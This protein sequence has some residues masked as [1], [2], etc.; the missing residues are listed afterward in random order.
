MHFANLIFCLFWLI[1]GLSKGR[2]GNHDRLR[3]LYQPVGTHRKEKYSQLFSYIQ[4][5]NN[6]AISCNEV[7]K[8]EYLPR[9]K[10]INYFYDNVKYFQQAEMKSRQ[11]E[12]ERQKQLL[13]DA[14]RDMEKIWDNA[15]EYYE[16][17][18]EHCKAHSI[19]W[20]DEYLDGF[21]PF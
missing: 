4:F 1:I 8:K 18:K 11:L 6:L 14:K 5:Y 15:Q 16:L 20:V 10:E 19:L 2:S 21:P 3:V 17:I 7:F 12:V 9:L 13:A